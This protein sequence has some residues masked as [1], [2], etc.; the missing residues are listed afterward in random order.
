MES[1]RISRY[2]KC[3]RCGKYEKRNVNP[4]ILRIKCTTCNKTLK[5]IHEND[6]NSYKQHILQNNTNN[7]PRRSNHNQPYHSPI[8]SNYYINH[9]NDIFD[10]YSSVYDRPPSNKHHLHRKHIVNNNETRRQPHRYK[11]THHYPTYVNRYEPIENEDNAFSNNMFN[12]NHHHYQR[13]HR[14]GHNINHLF[15]DLYFNS[16]PHYHPNNNNNNNIHSLSPFYHHD[17]ADDVFDPMFETFGSTLNAFFRNNFSSNFRSNINNS[18]LNHIINIIQSNA[19]NSK[20]SKHPPT[21]KETLAKLKKF[22]MSDK[23]CKRNKTNGTYELPNCCICI[24]E[25]AK[26]ENTVLLPCGHMFHWN[27]CHSWLSGNNTCPICRF[28]LPA[29]TDN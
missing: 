24:S 23:Y 11:S 14:F 8:D 29:E 6:Y 4:E 3:D 17:F 20:K 2:F 28:E 21:K 25:I 10:E 7:L 5:E 19:E 22:P 12:I 13:R 26:G 15:D 16:N 9:L 18:I 27:C 1:N